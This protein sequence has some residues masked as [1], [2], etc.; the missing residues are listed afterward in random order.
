MMI[1]LLGACCRCGA[2]CDDPIY[3]RCENLIVEEGKKIGEEGAS[4]C[5]V[6]EKRYNG[7]P[8][9]VISKTGAILNTVCLKDS[10]EETK[11]IVTRGMGRGCSLRVLQ[12]DERK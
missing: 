9:R 12:I 5:G 8:I 2:C 7:M 10:V 1:V 6:Y 3:G 11:E 4:R